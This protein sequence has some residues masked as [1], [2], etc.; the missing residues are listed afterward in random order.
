MTAD[1]PPR[2]ANIQNIVAI[3]Q[4]RRPL[5]MDEPSAGRRSPSEVLDLIRKGHRVLDTRSPEAFGARHIPGATNVQLDGSEFEQRVGW[6]LSPDEAVV[7]G[8]EAHEAAQRA[9]RKLAFVGLDQGVEGYVEMED[10][11][12]AG[13]P[14]ASLS[15]I[16]VDQLRGRLGRDGL[17]VLDVRE[18][19]EWNRGHIPGALHLNFKH[20]PTRLGELPL[21]REDRL[22]VICAS[23]MRSS[24][25]CSFLLRNGYRN[26]LNVTG[27]MR[28]WQNAGHP[29]AV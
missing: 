24:T 5:T 8:V 11:E 7:L 10:W 26:L 16:D 19:S 9:V 6:M 3:N 15:Q 21:G 18:A 23:G 28:A 17:K 1:Q 4:G 14:T 12:S 20:L 2:P 27:G 13:L 22:A 29:L 25:A